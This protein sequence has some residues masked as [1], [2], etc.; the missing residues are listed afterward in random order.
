LENE[1]VQL[2]KNLENDYQISV[3]TLLYVGSDAM[4][5]EWVL[6]C[7]CVRQLQFAASGRHPLVLGKWCRRRLSAARSKSCRRLSSISSTHWRYTFTTG[8][9]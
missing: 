3:R 4:Q 6:C 1:V 9:V 8:T 2:W 5:G 7:G